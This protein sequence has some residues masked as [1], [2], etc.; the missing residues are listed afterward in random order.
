MLQN[1]AIT[2]PWISLYSR[3]DALGL[4]VLI[5]ISLILVK[6]YFPK[7]LNSFYQILAECFG[8]YNSRK[9]HKVLVFMALAGNYLN[10][11]NIILFML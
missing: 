8:L 10:L 11:H 2:Y 1:V 9:L 5:N 7:I 3:K 6:F 4:W